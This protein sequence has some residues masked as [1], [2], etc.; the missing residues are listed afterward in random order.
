M[1]RVVIVG[2]DRR[3]LSVRDSGLRIERREFQMRLV[4]FWAIVAARKRQN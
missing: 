3:D 2:C 4:L 1:A